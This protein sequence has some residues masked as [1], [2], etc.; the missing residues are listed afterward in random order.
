MGLPWRRCSGQGV[1]YRFALKDRT[2]DLPG[3]AGNFGVPLDET[4]MLGNFGGASRVPSSI[5][6]FKMER[7]TSLETLAGKGLILR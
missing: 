6:N 2:W 7:G 5:S 4:G 1:K 3:D